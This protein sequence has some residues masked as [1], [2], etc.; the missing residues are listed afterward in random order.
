[1]P[2]TAEQLATIIDQVVEEAT[3]KPAISSTL[4]CAALKRSVAFHVLRTQIEDKQTSPE[5]WVGGLLIGIQLG[6]AIR[7]VEELEGLGR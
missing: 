4:L 2:M 1:M 7:E 5:A 3:K 6:K